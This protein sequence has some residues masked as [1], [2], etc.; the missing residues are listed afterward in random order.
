M[1]FKKGFGLKIREAVLVLIVTVGAIGPLLLRKVDIYHGWVF[2]F[3]NSWWL[4][5][6]YAFLAILVKSLLIKRKDESEVYGDGK[7]KELDKKK[8]DG[9]I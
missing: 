5:V 4:V 1:I 8:G 3:V 6:Y 7:E 9:G 2:D